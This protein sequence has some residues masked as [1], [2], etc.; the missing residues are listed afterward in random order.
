MRI[1]A[2]RSLAILA[3]LESTPRARRL[4]EQ[5]QDASCNPSTR[6]PHRVPLLSLAP[7]SFHRTSS[8]RASSTAHQRPSTSTKRHQPR[9]RPASFARRRRLPRPCPNPHPLASHS[10]R[11]FGRPFS[12]SALTCLSA[13]LPAKHTS[14]TAAIA[15]AGLAQSRG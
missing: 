12:S 8:T 3:S 14:P 7:S 6:R 2:T 9:R 4:R 13:R 11:L 15:D 5:H 10:T 1:P